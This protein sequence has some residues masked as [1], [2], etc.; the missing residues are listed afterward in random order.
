VA[1]ARE[2]LKKRR[3]DAALGDD[4]REVAGGVEER[5]EVG[6]GEKLAHRFEAALATAESGQPVVNNRNPHGGGLSQN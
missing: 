4:A 6:L 2:A 1:D 5:E 3:D